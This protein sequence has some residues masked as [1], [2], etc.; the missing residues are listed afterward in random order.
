MPS[1]LKNAG[2]TYQRLV[3]TMFKD[4]LGKTMEVYIDDM[5]VKSER[6][7]DHLIH[8]KEAFAI[9]RQFNMKLNPEKCAFGVSSGKFLGFMVSKGVSKCG[10]NVRE[11]EGKQS[12]ICYVSKT[13]LD[14]ETRYPHLEKL[15][16]ALIQ[17][18]RKLR[19]YFQSHPIVVVTTFPLRSILHR[20]ELSGRLAKWA[21]DLSEFDISYQPRNAIKSQILADFVADFSS[22]LYLKAEK[23]TVT[24]SGSSPGIWTLYTDGASNE[25][26]SGLGL[27]LKVPSGEIVG[28]SIKCP[29]ITNNEAEYVAVVAGLKLALEYRAESIK[30]HCDSQLVVNQGLEQVPRE[31]NTEACGLAKLASAADLAEPGSR[32]VIHLLHPISSEIEI[33]AT[34][35]THDWRNKI[36]DYLQ[37]GTLPSDKKEARKLRVKASRYCLVYGELYRRTFGGPLAKRLGL[38]ETEPAMQQVHSGYC[39]NHSG[40]RSL[41]RSLLRAGYYWNTIGK[42]S[43]SFV[44]RCKECQAYASAIHQPEEPLHSVI[45]SWTF[46]KWGLDIMGPFP[47]AKGKVKFK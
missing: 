33:R 19:Q 40:G 3:N 6:A 24:N 21:I 32:S 30:V 47:E 34:R 4:Q 37:Q 26:V 17:A 14:A 43:Q 5:V 27:V 46:M 16:L 41:A 28:Q 20:P 29:K 23:E 45:T 35:S 31:S 13:L 38:A 42:D 10:S 44:R 18:A 9:L 22:K 1:G 12:P 7:E 36:L 8:L 2:A 25:S 11:D 39:G 15:A